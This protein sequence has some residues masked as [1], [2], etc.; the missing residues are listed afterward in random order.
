M[1]KFMESLNRCIGIIIYIVCSKAKYYSLGRLQGNRHW[2]Y[3]AKHS[4]RRGDMIMGF[5][6]TL[7]SA[8]TVA[9]LTFGRVT[10]C[11]RDIY[12]SEENFYGFI[13]FL[14]QF[15][16]RMFS[17]DIDLYEQR[18][19]RIRDVLCERIRPYERYKNT[20]RCDDF[21][22]RIDGKVMD[23]LGDLSDLFSRCNVKSLLLPQMRGRDDGDCYDRDF[24]TSH[25]T[26]KYLV[27]RHP[28]DSC[29]ILQPE[30]RPRSSAVFI[31]AFPIFEVALKQADM[32][33]AVLFWESREELAFVPIS[34]QE[35]LWH[36]YEIV[37][38]DYRHPT[39]ELRRYAE[40]RKKKPNHYI[41]H[42]SD[43]HFGAQDVYVSER[44]LKSLIKKQLSDVDR[45]D[46][47]DFVITGDIYE[48]PERDALF[49]Y[50]NFADHLFDRYGKR[51]AFVLGNHDINDHGLA[52]S[53]N[54]QRLT[55]IVA[56]YPKI[57]ILEEPKV[58]LL[59][60]NSNTDGKLAQGK[61]GADQMA[62][63][64][65]LLDGV[66][67]VDG[68]LLIAIM[69]HHLLPIPK[70]EHYDKKWFEKIIP[71]RVMNETLKLIDADLFSE[72]LEARNV[73]LVLHGH[74]HIPFMAKRNNIQVIS[75]GSSTGQIAHTDKGKTCI[76]Y[77]LIKIGDDAITCTQFVEEIFGAGAKSIRTET[78]LKF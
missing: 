71:E 53:T 9:N 13:K 50:R 6:F 28:G 22:M 27:Q 7:E 38:Y 35:E 26:L 14:Y 42:L 56:D 20:G 54:N 17:D 72:W 36:L 75:C 63:M 40:K 58:V 8:N 45:G 77:N 76:S 69:H 21:E 60:F 39:Y 68:Y 55:N 44:R 34:C 70:P 4:K 61:I 15:S 74:K 65:N 29:L 51:P 66:A 31:N 64:G 52:F 11:Y 43:L 46:S 41:M 78:L 16:S 33:P 18:I 2:L 24:M 30:E 67:N 37:Y 48:S 25:D 12:N 62:E 32:W 19:L 59:L 49:D 23:A 10:A 1:K 47:L 57:E 3:S 5:H 73:N